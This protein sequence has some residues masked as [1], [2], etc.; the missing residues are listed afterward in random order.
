MWE[1][2]W[3]AVLRELDKAGRL[4]P[5]E[6]ALD[7]DV[8]GVVLGPAVLAGIPVTPVPF[9][10]TVLA[11]RAYDSDPLRNQLAIDRFTILVDTGGS[12]LGVGA[13]HLLAGVGDLEAPLDLHPVAVPGVLP[14]PDLTRQGVRV[15]DAAAQALPGQDAQL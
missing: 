11:D 3:R 2:V 13:V 15:R 8:P 7:A 1:R 12:L 4:N 14:R 10:V 5:S 9:G 6:L